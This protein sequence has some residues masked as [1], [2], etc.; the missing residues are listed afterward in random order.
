MVGELP[1]VG[2]TFATVATPIPFPT[3]ARCSDAPILP[4]A[5]VGQEPRVQAVNPLP[6]ADTTYS[7][8][9]PLLGHLLGMTGYVFVQQGALSEAAATVQAGDDGHGEVGKGVPQQG[10]QGKLG[11]VAHS[12]AEILRTH[13]EQGVVSDGLSQPQRGSYHHVT[14]DHLNL[15][16]QTLNTMF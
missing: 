3:D 6:S 15:Q 5:A 1:R 14:S 7:E 8:H 9:S 16:L 2:K 10:A 13:V 11:E 4:H 12:A